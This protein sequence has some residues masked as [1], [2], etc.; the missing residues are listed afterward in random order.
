LLP[1]NP[2]TQYEGARKS[3]A[4][5]NDGAFSNRSVLA[6]LESALWLV[7]VGRLPV[8]YGQVCGKGN[9]GGGGICR[10]PGC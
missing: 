6:V 4:P 2:L 1:K 8:L 9:A 3:A 5:A 10:V 7:A